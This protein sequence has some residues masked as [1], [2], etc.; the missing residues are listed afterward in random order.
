M[1]AASFTLQLLQEVS[2]RTI[3]E[4]RGEERRGEERGT[5]HGGRE[6]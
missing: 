1:V 2:M 3:G 6:G 5:G 4:R